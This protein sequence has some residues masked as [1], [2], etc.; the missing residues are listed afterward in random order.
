MVS[1]S[2]SAHS[3]PL[4]NPVDGAANPAT[5]HARHAMDRTQQT[6][7]CASVETPLCMGSA[8]CLTAHSASTLM[9]RGTTVMRAHLN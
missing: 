1:A 8:L 5:A 7:T 4:V 6:V 9:V 2:N 3:R